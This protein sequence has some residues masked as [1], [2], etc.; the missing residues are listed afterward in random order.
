MDTAII[1]LSC[2][3]LILGAVVLLAVIS[4]QKKSGKSSVICVIEM[5]N[6]NIDK[7]KRI[8]RLYKT[9][10]SKLI[11]TIVEDYFEENKVK[12][13]VSNHWALGALRRQS[14]A[15]RRILYAAC[16]CPWIPGLSQR[17]KKQIGFNN[18]RICI[19]H[20]TVSQISFGFKRNGWPY[21]PL[22]WNINFWP[23]LF[24]FWK[25]YAQWGLCF[26]FVLQQSSQ[27]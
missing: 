26:Y 8:K 25:C 6:E 23:G 20:Q 4:S 1:V 7:L 11:E 17:C 18:N 12:K 10:Q 22:W 16:R 13:D 9:T 14:N 15:K 27:E 5:K 24:I 19:G 3:L 2:F 21:P